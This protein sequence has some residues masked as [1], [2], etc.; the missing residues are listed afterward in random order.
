MALT[1]K[2]PTDEEI[3]AADPVQLKE[4]TAGRLKARLVAKDLKCINKLPEEQTFAGVPEMDAV[5]LIIASTESKEDKLSST[6]FDTAYLQT[7]ED[8]KEDWILTKR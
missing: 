8:E 6:D 1:W 7:P 5:R 3:A 2:R 4:G